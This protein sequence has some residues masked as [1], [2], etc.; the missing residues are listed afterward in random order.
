MTPSLSPIRAAMAPVLKQ[1]G[2]KVQS[3]TWHKS[4]Q[5]TIL[6]VNLQK[7]QWSQRY[8]INLAVWVRA[9]GEAVAPKEH[10]CH[11]RER[12]TSLPGGEVQ[13]L[14]RALDLDDGVMDPAQRSVCVGEFLRQ[15]A[16]PFLESLSTLGGIRSAF[17]A[18]RL[19]GCF[20]HRQLRPLLS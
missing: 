10:Q 9:L 13:E 8:Y 14:E 12:A 17:V 7:S 20:V 16:L 3:N 4:C 19:K 2:F 6:V 18:E 1:A 15:T 5:D 11:I